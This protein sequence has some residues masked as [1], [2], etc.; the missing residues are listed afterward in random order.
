MKNKMIKKIFSAFLVINTSLFIIS[1]SISFVLLFR[2]FYYYHIDYL[3]ISETSGYTKDEIK[4]A[5]DDVIDYIVLDKTF[6][7]GKLNYSKDGYDHF[8]DCKVLFIINFII[9]GFS[10]GI[11]LLK[12]I[13][14][15]NIKLFKY[16]VCMWS[17]VLNISIFMIL[18]FVSK[19]IS[20]DKMFE[21]F[22]RIFFMGKDNWLFD[23]NTDEIIKILPKEFFM[24]CAILIIFLIFII[25]LVFIIKEIV[26]KRKNTLKKV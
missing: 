10:F 1:L 9:L 19:I 11:I 25:S 3:N 26:S 17:S 20:F 4:E 16:N 8:K 15:K 23:K 7:T 6:K 5:Y 2:P 22:H 24:N 12:R 18:F 14:L 13:Y 21:L